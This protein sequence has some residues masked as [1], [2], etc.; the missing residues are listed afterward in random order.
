MAH[1][2]LSPFPSHCGFTPPILCLGTACLL[3]TSLFYPYS[4]S[5]GVQTPAVLILGTH[6]SSLSGCPELLLL[7]QGWE[8][9]KGSDGDVGSI[10][11]FLTVPATLL[12]WT[13]FVG[14]TRTLGSMQALAAD[15]DAVSGKQTSSSKALL[16]PS[17]LSFSALPPHFPQTSPGPGRGLMIS[18]SALGYLDSA[19]QSPTVRYLGL[20]FGG[21]G[22]PGLTQARAGKV[23]GAKTD[24]GTHSNPNIPS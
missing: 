2:Y 1:A 12:G 20:R 17:P 9:G 4:P 23:R 8:V 10:S 14:P 18:E 16:T 11:G 3:A 24:S 22:P 7:G 13:N 15:M 6:H 21:P 5:S 19:W